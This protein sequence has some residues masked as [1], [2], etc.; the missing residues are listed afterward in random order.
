MHIYP[1]IT[2]E[3][4]NLKQQE[5]KIMSAIRTYD[6]AMTGE[7]EDDTPLADLYNWL[8]T[9]RDQRISLENAVCIPLPISAVESY[10]N[11]EK[12]AQTMREAAREFYDKVDFSNIEKDLEKAAVK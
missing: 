5:S 1:D 11:V 9:Y 3:I 7:Y 6:P 10:K 8:E 12:P 4:A 2:T